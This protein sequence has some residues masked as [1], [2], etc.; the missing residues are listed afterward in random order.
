M[1]KQILSIFKSQIETKKMFN[2][3]GVLT[4][5]QRYRF[6]TENLGHYGEKLSYSST[7]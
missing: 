1:V 6:Q 7:L 3:I 4:F 5:L 2:F